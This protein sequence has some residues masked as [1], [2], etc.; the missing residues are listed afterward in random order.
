MKKTK[1][2]SELKR[3]GV[4]VVLFAIVLP[5]LLIILGFTIDYANIQRV[6]NEIR[7]VADLSAKAAASKLSQTN[8]PAQ[9]LA[10]AQA[11]AAA[12]FVG[13]QSVT[14]EPS[15]VTFGHSTRNSSG[16]FDFTPGIGPFNGVQVSA[17][18]DTSKGTGVD[19]F[20]GKLYGR[21]EI[22]L[23]QSA[24]ASFLNV[25][26]IL[27]LDRSGSM[28]WKT[29]GQMTS[30]ELAEV[31]CKKPNPQSRWHSLDSAVTV[32]LNTLNQS[33][34]QEKV[35]LVTFA[36]DYSGFCDGHSVTKSKLDQ[37]LTANLSLIQ[38]GMDEYNTTVWDGATNIFAGLNEARLHMEAN[39]TPGAEHVI[40]VLTDG[41]FN[42]GPAPF[43]EATACQAAGITVHTI[44]FSDDA[45]Q[46]DMITT[47]SNGG[48][49]H[50]H[51]NDEAELKKVFEKIAGSFAI[52]TQ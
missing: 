47:A 36:S 7:A 5:V 14:L 18:R 43:D 11:T 49:A 35:G 22:S 24:T 13:G 20:F 16:S 2:K 48:G 27:V 37:S 30:T 34:V 15:Q 32:F 46:T 42:N 17:E 4:L 26:I 10:A 12:N 52:L 8:D 19:L 3:R 25:D 51:A 39:K 41:V 50:H 1:A 44:T 33:P 38:A 45:N 31:A 29:V 6:R 28:K 9:A 21:E 23:A 40:V